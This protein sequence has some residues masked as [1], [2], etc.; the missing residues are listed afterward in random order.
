MLTSLAHAYVLTPPD[1][2]FGKL[3]ECIKTGKLEYL[4]IYGTIQLSDYADIRNIADKIPKNQPFPT[5]YMQSLGGSMDAGFAIGRV[6]RQRH[7]TVRSGNPIT[8][9]RYSKC[10]SSCMLIASGAVHRYLVHIGIHSPASYDGDD[11]AIDSP[12]EDYSELEK[13]FTEMGIDHRVYAMLRATPNS[14]MLNLTLDPKQIGD[15]QYIV[16]LGYYQ[17]PTATSD[18]AEAEPIRFTHYL[19][20][21]ASVVFAAMNGSHVALNQLIDEYTYGSEE[22]PVDLERARTWLKIGAENSDITSLHNLGVMYVREKN[23][24]AAVP[25]FKRAAELGFA[26]SQN[27]YGWHLYKGHGVKRNKSEAVFWIARA[28]EQ[29]DPFA[30]GSLCEIYGAADVFMPDNIEAMKWCRLASDLM[31]MG[32]ARDAAVKFMD[33]FAKKITDQQSAEA[34]KR[35]DMWQPLK[36]DTTKAIDIDDNSKPKRRKY[37]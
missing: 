21:K 9:D 29:G 28:A 18:D 27:N 25:L 1:C 19:Y 37:F 3:N 33:G 24:A 34:N 15:M 7:A 5:I 16:Q 11:N 8:G 35:A 36:Q 12:P 22:T 2:R 31:P 13:Y 10:S 6:L 26:G 23:D 4:V 32:K 30:Y 17:G 20:E 14:E